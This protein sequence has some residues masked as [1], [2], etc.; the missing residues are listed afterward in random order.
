MAKSKPPK[1]VT[2]KRSGRKFTVTWKPGETY[3]DQDAAWY[4]AKKKKWVELKPG[5][6]ARSK[7]IKV[8]ADVFEQLESLQFRVRGKA[9]KKSESS[10]EKKKFDLIKPNAPSL[11]YELNTSAEN[12][13]TFS[14]NVNASDTDNKVFQRYR[15]QSVTT[16]AGAAPTDGDYKKSGNNRR[17]SY[18]TSTTGSLQIEET[19]ADV[20]AG[21]TRWFRIRSEGLKKDVSAWVYASHTYAAASAARIISG[22]QSEN[23]ADGTDVVADWQ[24]DAKRATN[25]I[26][27]VTLQWTIATPDKNLNCPDD[28][29]WSDGPTYSGANMSGESAKF[30]IDST[31]GVDK[32]LFV[33]A[34]THHDNSVTYG[35]PYVTKYGM[36]Q[37]PTINSV[38][39]NDDTKKATVKATNNSD[40]PGSY[41]EVYYVNQNGKSWPV[42]VIP[43]GLD[44]A[45]VDFSKAVITSAYSFSVQAVSADGKKM[46]SNTVSQGGTVPLAPTGVA[47]STVDDETIRVV[48]DWTWQ[49]AD[50]AE[51]A[52]ADH[53][54][55]WMSNDEPETYTVSHMHASAWNIKG[56]S[57]G[58]TWYFR[59]RLTK[60]NDSDSITYGDWSD[61][62]AI[63]LTE[64]PTRPALALSSDVVVL[65]ETVTASWAYA[66]GDGTSQAYAEICEA[67]IESFFDEGGQSSVSIKYGNVVAN[68]TSAQSVTIDPVAIGWESGS[69]HYLCARVTSA[70]GKTSD[71]WSAAVPLKVA[72]ALDAEMTECSLSDVTITD[73]DGNEETVTALTELPMTATII[74]AGAGGTT[75]LIIERAEDYSTYR[76]DERNEDSFEGE[77]I[78]SMS[79]VGQSQMT[80]DASDLIGQLDDGAQ[81]RLIGI[82]SDDLGQTA[83]I[84]KTFEVH[85]K[86]QPS[87]PVVEMEV[88]Q[89]DRIVKITA[90]AGEDAVE[91]DVIDIYRISA[92]K[93]QLIIEGGSF[94]TTYVDPYPAFGE[95]C[96][97][98]VVTRSIYGDYITADNTFAWQDVQSIIK[99]ENVVI[100]WDEE[101]VELPYNIKIDHSWEKDFERTEYLGGSVEGD[102]N[103]QVLKEVTINTDLIRGK[104]EELV[105]RMHAL[106]SFPGACHVRTPDGASFTADVS[107][108]ESRGYESSKI[109]YSIKASAIDPEGYEG[110]TLERWDEMQEDE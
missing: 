84:A 67:T 69:T 90:T 22:T 2:I 102:W 107:V 19:S 58:K 5:K 50:S 82:V 85:W 16:P 76:P 71:G 55:A 46:T 87:V 99:C 27:K 8:D 13:G 40:L 38:T 60:T 100:E 49:E 64:A 73:D 15:Y 98:R 86:H 62:V 96:G 53:D 57:A 101:L 26:D 81:Y 56:L 17:E 65:G 54:D 103:P 32:A 77:T 24:Y 41:L 18:G 92:D 91:T 10:Y 3:E 28:A 108:S 110:V 105:R 106:A 35:A 94:G 21:I 6:A 51:I 4:N 78:V 11:S 1:G 20:K 36:L 9:K 7:T 109:S 70:S 68:A 74:G 95:G 59:V 48:W 23:S 89:N 93:P 45:I 88:D 44:T 75:T 61:V 104:D 66:T 39:V 63:D 25:P 29:S 97:H 30:S 80:I 42:G 43:N 83:Q 12:A 14:W 79:Q 34:N 31:I 52:W 33:R 37:D 47:L 72:E